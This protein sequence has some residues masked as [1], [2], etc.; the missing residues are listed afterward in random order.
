MKIRSVAWF[1]CI[2]LL[3]MSF[4]A[5]C[6][7]GN[8]SQSGPSASVTDTSGSSS[9]SPAGTDSG[10]GK[11]TVYPLTIENYT[12]SGESLEAEPKQQVFDKAPE[13]VVANTQAVAELL[14]K[15]G[16]VDKLVGVAALYGDPDPEVPAEEFAKVPVLSEGYVSKEIVVGANPDLVM[17]RAGLFA[18]ADWGV[19]TVEGL[20]ELGIRTYIHNTSLPGATLDSLYRDITEIGQIFDIQEKAEEY[21]E[22]LQHRVASL[23]EKYG[24]ES[25]LKF[26]IVNDIGDGNISVDSG[27]Y[28]SF[29][30]DVLALIQ[31]KNAFQG[32]EGWEASIEQLVAEKPDVLLLSYY[33]GAPDPQST[34]DAIYANPALQEI[35]AVQNKRIYVID[36]NAFWGYGDQIIGA[37]EKLAQ[38]IYGY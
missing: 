38:E 13:R 19:G 28:D 16:L 9:E 30:H 35:P 5:A 3:L 26:A 25:T 32:I 21:L 29:Q 8:T 36:F 23:K 24:N 27:T 20:N 14:I 6:S 4:M 37:V 1:T 17:G 12:V 18:D 22:K 10:A 11:R 31:L 7:S 2:M 34:I 15:L 33:K